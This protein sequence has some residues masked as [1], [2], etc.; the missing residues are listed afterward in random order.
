MKFLVFSDVVSK[1]IPM[2]IEIVPR[3]ERGVILIVWKDS[4]NVEKSS[5]IKREIDKTIE[6]IKD[7]KTMPKSEAID[8]M[9]VTSV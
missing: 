1:A 8:P 2:E 7:P 3:I 9:I 5:V 4:P 6:E